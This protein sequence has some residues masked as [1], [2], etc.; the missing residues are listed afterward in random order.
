MAE[1]PQPRLLRD[2]PLVQQLVS[3]SL[4]Q[5]HDQKLF[6]DQNTNG[7]DDMV[8][9]SDPAGDDDDSLTTAAS[10]SA[11]PVDTV[12]AAAAQQDTRNET[13]F[14]AAPDP[15]YHRGTTTTLSDSSWTPSMINYPHE[16]P[17]Y[18]LRNE[19]E[20]INIGAVIRNEAEEIDIGAVTR[21]EAEELSPISRAIYGNTPIDQERGGR[22]NQ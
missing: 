4:Q 11:S 3:N 5:E 19:A 21:D 7:G 18:Q 22:A 8:L 1:P 16:S 6:R 12:P 17:H 10:P 13:W 14:V 15:Y 20:E 2:A 9:M